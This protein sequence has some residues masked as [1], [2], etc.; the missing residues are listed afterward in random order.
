[1]TLRHPDHHQ[2]PDA[3]Y[4]AFRTESRSIVGERAGMASGIIWRS[5]MEP[6][7]GSVRATIA[8]GA[9]YREGGDFTMALVSRNVRHWGIADSQK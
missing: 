6:A 9:I 5:Y 2:I 1:M 8:D 4:T 3:S 7:L